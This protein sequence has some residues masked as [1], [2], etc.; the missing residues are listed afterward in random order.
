MKSNQIKNRTMAFYTYCLLAAL[1][2]LIF[3]KLSFR[4]I[5]DNENDD[6]KLRNNTNFQTKIQSFQFIENLNFMLTVF[7]L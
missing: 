3:I 7:S 5:L 6:K 2:N 4:D 1:P